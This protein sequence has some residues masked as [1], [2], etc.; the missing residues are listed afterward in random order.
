MQSAGTEPSAR[1]RLS[2]KHIEWADII[3]CMEQKHKQRMAENFP[4]GIHGKNI[5]VLHIP[6]VYQYMDVELIE[7]LNNAVEEYL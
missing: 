4:G 6:D 2:A 7:M 1:I 3:F 5:I